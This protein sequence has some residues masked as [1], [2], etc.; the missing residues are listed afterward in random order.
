[1]KTIRLFVTTILVLLSCWSVFAQSY[2]LKGVVTDA[3]TGEP[4][5]FASV[6]LKG[7][8]VGVACDGDGLYTLS[9][10][11][12]KDNVVIFSSIGY[13]RREVNIGK[14]LVCNVSLDSDV[15]ALQ[16]T[17]VVA[18]GTSTKESFTGSATVV[19]S[20]D[21]AKTQ[22]SDATR[23]L[24]GVVAGV[25]MTT[26]SGSLGASPSIII[27]GISSI[28]ASKSPLYVV[29]GV[30]YS[31]DLNLIN[32]ADIESMT[33]LKD[34]ASNAL[35]GA[36]GAN[37][38]IMITTKKASSHDAI[39]TFDAKWGWNSKALQDYEIIKDPGQYY[40]MHY[41]A[42]KQYYMYE[43]GMPASY[44]H[45]KAATIL[46][47]DPKDGGLGYNVYTVPEGQFL[48]GAN[49]RLNPNATLGRV[50]EYEGK[51]F[52][53][54]P[55]DWMKE[56]YRSSFRHEYN[57]SVAGRSD[58]GN[59]YASIGYLNNNAIIRY[60]D[61][62]R[63]T[64]RLKAD[65]QAKKW[66]KVGANFSYSHFDFNNGNGTEGSN[67]TGNVFAF[68]NSVAPIYPLYMRNAD[69]STM[70]DKYG[71]IRYDYGAGQNGGGNRPVQ[72]NANAFQAM[73]LDVNNT[74]G[75]AFDGN[76]FAR[77]TFLKDFTFEVNAGV[78]L[79]EKRATSMLNNLYGQYAPSGGILDKSHSRYLHYNFQQLLTYD[80]TI[81]KHHVNVL[82]GH[83]NYVRQTYSVGASKKKLFSMD[84]LE[85]GGAII[86]GKDARSSYSKYNNEGYFLRAQ[87]DYA[88]KIFTSVSYRRD[89]SSRFHPKYRWGDF[90]SLGA[91]WLINHE[92]WFNAKWVDLLKIK[93]SVGSQGNDGIGDNLYTDMYNIKNNQDEIA[94][95]FARKGN[96][97]ITWETNTNFNIGVD[98]DFL[99]GR[100]GGSIEYFN[101][102]TTDMLFFFTV[103]SSL[104][105]SGYYTNVGD[106]KNEGVEFSFNFNPIRKKNF[107]WNIYLNATHYKNKITKLPEQFKTINVEGYDGY[108][109]GLSFLGEGLSI[110]TF[111]MPKYAGVDQETGRSLWYKNEYKKDEEGNV[112]K[113]KKGHPIVEKVGTTTQYS[114]GTQYLCGNPTPKLYGGFGTSM[115]F[116]GF[117]LA[118]QFTYQIGG[119]V[120]DGGYASLMVSP[121]ASVGGNFHKDLLKAWTPENPSKEI[122]RMRFLDQNTSGTSNRFLTDASYLN[123]Q[124]LQFGYSLPKKFTRDLRIE[125]LRFYLTC[126]NVWYVSQRKGLDPRQSFSGGTNDAMN[127]P[128]RTL[129]GGVTIT[130]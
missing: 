120:Y 52:L 23:A 107:N 114:E 88:N 98:F 128:V 126:D 40:E 26:S 130:F 3:E 70:R 36:R 66:L 72:M 61:M 82:L 79:M 49:G 18:F 76:G 57:L 112:V 119:L 90:W 16:E 47:G 118:I 75:N 108:A 8:K 64:A 9:L 32:P 86:D 116:F 127:S 39:V 38:V 48:I 13:Q 71:N 84:N 97:K 17:M 22:S 105:Y 104:G 10:P 29:D 93:A 53:L 19:K 6:L 37:G 14:K 42:L 45:T 77:I 60:S 99:Q 117:D 59:F 125:K 124:N 46:T 83:E 78:G 56:A 67:D 62:Q 111:Y 5:P 4:I 122:P 68:A 58:K 106:M 24:E 109:T 28:S 73:A 101:R 121:G 25:Q 12:G 43:K 27:R 21:I 44:A 94:V 20:A 95:E 33:V 129:S 65:Y 115:E 87:Y 7:T 103:P 41:G 123:I 1:M 55:D 50:V 91:G 51:E 100:I 11:E 2:E 80:K 92:P 89:A 74:E 35:Y 102:M 96:E 15:N 31:G 63:L 69:G 110:N 30:P 85:L 113:D 34:A 54:R 81:R